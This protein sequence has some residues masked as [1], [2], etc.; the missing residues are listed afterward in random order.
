MC[1]RLDGA[2]NTE[3]RAIR[4]VQCAHGRRGPS[5]PLVCK[6]NLLIIAGSEVGLLGTEIAT[7]DTVAAVIR[8][9]IWPDGVAETT[10][11]SQR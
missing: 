5:A 8:S 6:V 7:R 2:V 3:P 9:A 4:C 11:T 1:V 10:S